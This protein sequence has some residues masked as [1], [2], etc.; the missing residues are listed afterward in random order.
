[1]RSGYLLVLL[2][3]LTLFAGLGRPA[4]SDSDEAFYAEAGREMVA[5]GDWLTIRL[6]I[7]FSHC[8]TDSMR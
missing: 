7:R 6:C 1:M 8:E 3:I 2:A 4:I 5:G